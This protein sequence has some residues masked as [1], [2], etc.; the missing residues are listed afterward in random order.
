MHGSIVDEIC[1]TEV[2]IDLNNNKADKTNT[3]KPFS[4]QYCNKSFANKCKMKRHVDCVHFK[5]K[6][7]SCQY[8]EKSFGQKQS[9][10]IHENAVHLKIKSFSCQHCDKS[11][12]LKY[13]MKEHINSVH[14]N[15]KTKL[16]LKLDTKPNVG[17][18]LE[19]VVMNE[20]PRDNKTKA[21]QCNHCK[22]FYKNRSVLKRHVNEVH[23]KIK[24]YF[25]K[26]C[27]YSCSRK[28]DMEKHVNAV[29]LKIHS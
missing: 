18:N 19:G 21:N 2:K 29:H 5:V 17:K 23:L 13:N 1:P 27:K 26:S 16:K 14:M 28:G 3:V 7:F 6:P 8:C 24:P 20:K 11:F 12:G 15:I 25:C 22:S 9:C 4:C 10:R